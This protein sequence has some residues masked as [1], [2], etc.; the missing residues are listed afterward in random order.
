MRIIALLT[1]LLAVS[2]SVAWAQ[3]VGS[4][5]P[6]QLLAQLRPVRSRPG[7]FLP[8][9]L[10]FP[11]RLDLE[12]DLKAARA[13]VE[14]QPDDL[15]ARRQLAQLLE[16]A[17]DESAESAWREVVEKIEPQLRRKPADPVLLEQLVEAMVGADLGVRVVPPAEQLRSAAP[18]RWQVQLLYGDARLRRADFNWRVCVRLGER[19]RSAPQ[20]AELLGDVEAAA[21]AY[22]RAV[23]LA[24]GE[25]AVRGARISLAMARVFMGSFLPKD[26]L[27]GAE[28]VDT[29]ALQK[30]LVSLCRQKPT[31]VDALWHTAHF[32][33]TFGHDE[34]PLAPEDRTF[35]QTVLTATEPREAAEAV[36]LAEARGMWAASTRDWAAARKAFE[37][38][39]ERVPA[40][41]FSS[42]W[43]TRCDAEG[44]DKPT[45]VI[46]RLRERLKKRAASEDYALLGLLLGREDPAAGI[47][48]LRSAIALDVD[49][50]HARYNLALL[51]IRRRADSREARHHLQLALEA[52]PDNLEAR[53]FHGVALA[54]SGN[55][56]A[57][58]QHLQSLRELPQADDDLKHRTAAVL[59]ATGKTSEPEK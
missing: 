24:P 6:D 4:P 42:S 48:A 11:L 23:V 38:A 47:A 30:E 26:A 2:G 15:T 21:A 36:F 51:L 10:R 59:A 28:R 58:R 43:L 39:C 1:P 56:A 53:L 52:E 31:R 3:P 45:E 9:S 13:R 57:A 8:A 5:D 44:A 54:L 33:A 7:T 25:P 46:A 55:F 50:A 22:Q 49:N 17:E 40:R 12:A 14:T 32:L 20:F 35:F 19:A 34:R 37:D 27:A 18:Q 16:Q 41:R 29:A